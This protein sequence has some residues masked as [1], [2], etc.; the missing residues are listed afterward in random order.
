MIDQLWSVGERNHK[1][2]KISSEDSQSLKSS[3]WFCGV[4]DNDL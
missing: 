3:S 1:H 2:P 4:L